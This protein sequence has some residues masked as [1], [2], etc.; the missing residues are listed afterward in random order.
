MKRYSD[1]EFALIL[2]KAAELG[3]AP[4]A[5]GDVRGDLTLSDM[6]A[7]AAEAGLDPALVA[8]AARLVEVDDAGGSRLE[9]VI[10]APTRIRMDA[11]FDLVLDPERAQQVLAVI[12]AAAGRQGEGEVSGSAVAW[13]SVGEGTQYLATVHT[14][15]DTTKLRVTGDRRGALAITALFSGL[16]SI[17]TGIAVL[18]AGEVSGVQLSPAIALGLI[19]GAAGSVLAGGRAVWKASTRGVR[20]RVAHLVE[21]VSQSIDVMEAEPSSEPARIE[22]GGGGSE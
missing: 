3:R 17:A 7:I 8:R 16:G 10:G 2:R 5:S 4:G 15:G 9:R 11:E 18:V 22:D 6:K 14:E 1:E 12:R 20:E 21:S 19:G 13:H